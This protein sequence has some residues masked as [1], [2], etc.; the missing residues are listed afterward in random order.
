MM[1][2]STSTAQPRAAGRSTGRA[3]RRKAFGVATEYIE[4]WVNGSHTP[5]LV[6][7]SPDG[8]PQNQAGVLPAAT[9]LFGNQRINSAG[10]PAAASRSVM[11]ATR[12]IWWAL[13]T[14]SYSSATRRKGL[15]SRPM[16]RRFWLGRS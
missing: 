11:P 12:A 2:A 15:A 6:T 4:W 7:T 8:T 5:A 10:P 9:V 14:R 1:E 3:D 16:V 13:K